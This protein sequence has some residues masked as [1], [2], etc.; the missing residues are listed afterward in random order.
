GVD[1]APVGPDQVAGDGQP[2]TAAAGVTRRLEPL[3]HPTQLQQSRSGDSSRPSH[4]PDGLVAVEVQRPSRPPPGAGPE[5]L[6]PGS[7]EAE[8]EPLQGGYARR[9]SRGSS[10]ST[11]SSGTS[12]PIRSARS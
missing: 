9:S 11:A 3:Q 2:E 6:P 8:A 12:S 4:N 10:S 7:A 1:G 5:W